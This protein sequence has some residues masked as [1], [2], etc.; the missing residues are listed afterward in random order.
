MKIIS[1]LQYVPIWD[2]HS[3]TFTYIQIRQKYYIVWVSYGENHLLLC[4]CHIP[5]KT[6]MSTSFS[7]ILFFHTKTHWIK[8]KLN[9]NQ[10]WFFSTDFSKQNTL[11]NRIQVLCRDT[12]VLIEWS[13]A[14]PSVQRETEIFPLQT[15]FS[16][17]CDDDDHDKQG[18]EGC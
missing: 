18:R 12:R 1:T 7:W 14:F 9:W 11:H 6:K 17:W 4:F 16:F 3:H 15:L 10:C 2:S 13:T 5:L 8:K